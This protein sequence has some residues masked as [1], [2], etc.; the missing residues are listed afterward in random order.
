MELIYKTLLHGRFPLRK[1]F[2]GIILILLIFIFFPYFVREIDVTA[3]AIDPGIFS[4][5]ILA[6]ATILIFQA[7]DLQAE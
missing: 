7:V 2:A 1:E 5:V 3:A 4:A 6:I